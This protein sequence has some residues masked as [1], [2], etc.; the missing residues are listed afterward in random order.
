[1]DLTDFDLTEKEMVYNN[2]IFKF[3]KFNNQKMSR[4]KICHTKDHKNFATKNLISLSHLKPTLS[5][6]PSHFSLSQ[7]MHHLRLSLSSFN[8]PLWH[9]LPLHLCCLIFSA[10]FFSLLP[11]FRRPSLSHSLSLSLGR[12]IRSPFPSPPTA[13]TCSLASCRP[14]CIRRLSILLADAALLLNTPPHLSCRLSLS[15]P[16]Q[17]D[18]PTDPYCASAASPL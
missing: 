12:E 9:L 3:L 4:N 10:P 16:H 1:M 7:L 13:P 15:H 14:C 17:P 2:K 6:P 18:S 5:F 11:F 8:A